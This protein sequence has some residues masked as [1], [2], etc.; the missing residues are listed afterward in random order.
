[1]MHSIKESDWKRMRSMKDGLL[2]V[3]CTR[4]LN[5]VKS[6][7]EGNNTAAVHEK[8]LQLWKIMRK[9]DKLISLCFDD[10]NRSNAVMKLA[11]WKKS[12]LVSEEQLDK[13][14]KE[15]RERVHQIVQLWQ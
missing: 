11:N 3:A 9:E 10:L 14:S 13:F 1:M 7:I 2:E 12:D 6:H 15:T 8:Y 5:R 4:I